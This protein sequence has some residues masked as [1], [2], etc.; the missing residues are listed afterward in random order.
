MRISFKIYDFS[1]AAGEEGLY[2]ALSGEEGVASWGENGL[3]LIDYRD[4]PG[5]NCYCD[6][7]AK[8]E[9]LRRMRMVNGIDNSLMVNWIDTGDYHYMSF[10]TIGQLLDRTM[11]KNV[12]ADR[13]RQFPVEGCPVKQ[14]RT[15]EWLTVV[16]FDHHP[17]MQPSAF[18]D[19]LSCGGWMRTLLEKYSQVEEA[20][21]MGINP[22]L[23]MPGQSVRDEENA[24]QD[25]IPSLPATIG[26]PQRKIIIYPEG[27]ELPDWSTLKGKKVYISIDKDVLSRDYARTNWD[28][29]SMTLQ[30]LEES[31]KAIAA[32]AEIAGVDICGGITSEKG[33]TAEDFAINLNTD[34]RLLK[35]LSSL[36]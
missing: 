13:D 23:G 1:G 4:I 9:I 14:D 32:N 26:N 3:T 35:L 16:L 36:R 21:I 15:E 25:R 8:E 2:E 6:Q 34:L 33:G 5:T 30:Q 17:D 18:G 10:L 27:S 11:I 22:A 24:G 29:G 31:I 28:Q 20:I 19:M 7:E 12:I